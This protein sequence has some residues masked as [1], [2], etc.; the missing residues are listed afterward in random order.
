MLAS[1][2]LLQVLKAQHIQCYTSFPDKWLGP[3]LRLLDED[4]MVMHFPTTIEREALGIA[5]GAQLAGMRSALV[6]QNSGIGNLLNDWAS[7]ARNYAIP[8][9]WL[10]SDRGSPGEL[11]T[12]QMVWHGRLRAILQAAEIPCQ[13][14]TDTAQLPEIAALVQH[15]YATQ[16]CVAGLFPYAFWRDDLTSFTPRHGGGPSMTAWP[17]PLHVS[18]DVAS[19]VQR[20]RAAWR[21]FE[22]LECLLESLTT[23]FL[24]V[25]L[26]DPCKEV[27]A[28]RDRVETFYML[29]SM[30]LVL[31]LGVGF[32]QA[33]AA[34]GGRRK[35]VVV[36]GDGSQL[37]Q[38][39]ALGT[40]ARKQSDLALMVIDN[41]TYGSTGDQPTLTGSHVHLEALGRAFGLSN[42]A[43]V[44]TT[45]DLEHRLQAVLAAPGPSLTVVLVQP[46][47]PLTPLVP[48][49]PVAIAQ[50][51]RA[52][53][54]AAS[55]LHNGEDMAI[56][57]GVP[58][59]VSSTCILPHG[60]FWA[61]TEVLHIAEIPH[62]RRAILR[63][64]RTPEPCWTPY[65]RM[66]YDD[67]ALPICR[68]LLEYDLRPS[69]RGG[70]HGYPTMYVAHHHGR[71]VSLV[72]VQ[73]GG[74]IARVW[75][76]ED[77]Y[78][79]SCGPNLENGRR[80]VGGM[81]PIQ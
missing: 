78:A 80:R 37:M 41:G 34:L 39:G 57:G 38:L 52:T 24:F 64:S 63:G 13:T 77:E 5:V 42:T 73:C 33:Y 10:V 74:C 4:A 31:P 44:G 27:Y 66:A 2:A 45:R 54:A 43:T 48:L 76:K 16:Q 1:E 53:V 35:T 55:P 49:P 56:L 30:G 25:T 26:G 70:D 61:L 72:R 79:A 40:F 47:A 69:P 9:P 6:M 17:F 51:F 14:C 59:S 60:L 20:C 50:R 8:V 3:L 65:G 62:N 58:A 15:G 36:D 7:L 12:T 71:A 67:P 75:R 18:S 21:R 29:G 19:M 11:V 23:E 32:A 68:S 81:L 22:A 28:I 46:G